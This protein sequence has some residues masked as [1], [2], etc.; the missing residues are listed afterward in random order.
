VKPSDQS[1]VT[2]LI[3]AAGLASRFGRPKQLLDW[4]GKPLIR[5]VTDVAAASHVD[6]VI[7]VTGATRL[8]VERAL[9]GSGA[10]QVFNSDY[11]DGQSTSLRR[12]LA[13]LPD[14]VG[15]IVIL[16]ADQP[17]VSTSS[18]NRVIHQW[19]R[20]RS[21]IV[22]ARYHGTPSHPILFDASLLS[23][24]REVS[25]DQGARAVLRKDPERIAWINLDSDAPPD[26]DTEEDYRRALSG[27]S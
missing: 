16:L 22:Q 3:L 10:T 14:D 26:I 19:R 2:A 7:V 21:P 1:P 9:D 11:A 5:H 27:P 8:D 18:I 23:E 12:G 17:G 24:L 13:A 4:H 6:Q 20:E 15:A 25:G